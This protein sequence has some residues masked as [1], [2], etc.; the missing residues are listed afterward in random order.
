MAH[1]PRLQALEERHARL[2]MLIAEE[3]GRPRPDETELARLKREKL[4]L[5]DEM[6]RLRRESLNAA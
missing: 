1:A 6:E 4:K 2:E 3:D 5:R